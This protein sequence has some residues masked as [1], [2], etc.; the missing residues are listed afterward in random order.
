MVAMGSVVGVP[1]PLRP[2]TMHSWWRNASP[3]APRGAHSPNARTL[4]L[5]RALPRAVP[6][7]HA[8]A[9]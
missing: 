6:F 8:R 7:E 3:S 5:V 9:E 4:R 2:H 1:L